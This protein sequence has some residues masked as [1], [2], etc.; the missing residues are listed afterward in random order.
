MSEITVNERVGDECPNVGRPTSRPDDVGHHGGIV[1]RGDEGKQQQEFG[2]LLRR[3]CEE[4]ISMNNP[5]HDNQDDHAWIGWK[6]LASLMT[7]SGRLCCKMILRI[8]ARKI[9][10]RSGA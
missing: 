9:D 8:L 5:E 7:A 1:A 6:F 3:Q 4:K 2:R 10:S